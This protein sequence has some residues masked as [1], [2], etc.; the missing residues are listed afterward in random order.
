MKWK[1]KHIEK[2]NAFATKGPTWGKTP[3]MRKLFHLHQ[4]VRS[5]YHPTTQ[6]GKLKL[7]GTS[8][9]QSQSQGDIKPERS[10]PGIGKTLLLF[11][12]RKQA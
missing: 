8:F 11:Q 12:K 10:P 4:L 6:K 2:E 3:T 1:Q 7:R 9:G 5:Y